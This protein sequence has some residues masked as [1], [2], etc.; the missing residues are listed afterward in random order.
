MLLKVPLTPQSQRDFLYQVYVGIDSK[1]R[2]FTFLKHMT[3]NWFCHFQ[4]KS[5][6]KPACSKFPTLSCFSFLNSQHRSFPPS[7]FAL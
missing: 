3:Q 4:N 1:Q 6:G 2:C 7:T 5:V